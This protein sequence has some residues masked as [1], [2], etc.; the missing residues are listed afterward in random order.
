MIRFA[1]IAVALLMSTPTHADGWALPD[2]A[3]DAAVIRDCAANSENSVAERLTCG[4]PV[5]E[6]CREAATAASPDEHWREVFIHCLYRERLAWDLILNETYKQLKPR[7]VEAGLGDELVNMQRHWIAF[8]DLK[9]GWTS[10][11]PAGSNSVLNQPACL[12][13]ETA[14]R[15]IEMGDD[16]NYFP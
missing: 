14:R 15:A 10:G 2:P 12:K 7:A 8:R 6:T 4:D 1:A 13:E 16:L 9:C 5:F 11:I 3:V